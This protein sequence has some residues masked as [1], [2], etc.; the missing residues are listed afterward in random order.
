VIGIPCPA[1][2]FRILYVYGHEPLRKVNETARFDERLR[3]PSPIRE[4]LR[5]E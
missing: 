4:K 2:K 1:G 5:I 3:I